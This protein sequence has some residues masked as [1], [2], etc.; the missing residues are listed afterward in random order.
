MRRAPIELSLGQRPQPGATTLDVDAGAR[1]GDTLLIA[2]K[3]RVWTRVLPQRVIVIGRD[4]ACD[5]VVDDPVLSRQ[6]VR[7]CL[8]PPTTIEDLHSRNGTKVGGKVWKGGGV[9]EIVPAEGFAIGPF[10]F[11]LMTDSAARPSTQ[12]PALDLMSVADP[13]AEAASSLLVDLARGGINVLILGESGVGKEVLAQTLHVLSGREGPLQKIN[14]A[15]LPEQLLESEL[16]GHEK[17]AFTGASVA[18]AGLLEAASGGTVFLDEIGELPL[19]VQ[20]KLLRAIEAHEILRLGATR[21]TPIDVRFV[22]ATNRD[23]AAEVMEKRFRHD[24]YFRIDG[25]TLRIPPLRDRRG[26]IGRLALRFA[27]SAGVAGGL[28]PQVLAELERHDWPGNVRELKAV[29]E[30]AVLLAR[31]KPIAVSHL[32]FSPPALAPPS[33]G[34]GAST[35]RAGARTSSGSTMELP[36]LPGSSPEAMTD[37]RPGERLERDRILAALEA[38]AGNQT[39]AATLLGISRTALVTKLRVYRIPRPRA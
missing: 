28:S 32:A 36:V 4:P 18:R 8:G 17:G 38:C 24:L 13:T 10:S 27:Q 23:L 16:F 25:L 29:V 11:L 15:A 19:A 39:R 5:I 33:G 3:G 1:D 20:A 7:L 26:M 14:C 12:R 6:H 35:V 22:C 34:A 31:G 2:G 21:A 30:R 9:I 37:L